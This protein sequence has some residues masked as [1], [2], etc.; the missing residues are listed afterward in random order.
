MPSDIYFIVQFLDVNVHGKS[1]VRRVIVIA[2]NAL[3]AINLCE[4]KTNYPLREK[5]QMQR[6]EFLDIT[7]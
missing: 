1:W 2:E 6:I 5:F 4:E 7:P 3:E